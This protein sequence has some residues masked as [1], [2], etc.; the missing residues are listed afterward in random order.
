MC[1]RV[2]ATG[3]IGPTHQ[4]LCWLSTDWQRLRL[5]SCHYKKHFIS[6]CRTAAFSFSKDEAGFCQ[7]DDPVSCC[8]VL[9]EGKATHLSWP[10]DKR[11]NVTSERATWATYPPRS[12]G[13]PWRDRGPRVE[14]SIEWL[15]V[16]GSVNLI[17][18]ATARV[19]EMWPPQ[20]H[21]RTASQHAC[22]DDPPS[23]DA[24]PWLALHLEMPHLKRSNFMPVGMKLECCFIH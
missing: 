7:S 22:D 15:N 1:E 23:P 4:H 11:Q 20:S 9:S 10:T 24:A 8:S 18:A 16:C 19:N 12:S 2:H 5:M 17:S 3:K 6:S 13:D 21:Y 14:L